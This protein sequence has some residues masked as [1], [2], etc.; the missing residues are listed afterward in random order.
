MLKIH[1]TLISILPIIPLQQLSWKYTRTRW[2]GGD[3]T[4]NSS[5]SSCTSIT[6]RRSIFAGALYDSSC[7]VNYLTLCATLHSHCPSC[8]LLSPC[9]PPQHQLHLAKYQHQKQFS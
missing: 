5:S 2:D 3:A 6:S 4:L 1:I 9:L 8:L 7:C